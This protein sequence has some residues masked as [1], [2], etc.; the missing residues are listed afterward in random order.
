MQNS[1]NVL[2]R[3]HRKT[4]KMYIRGTAILMATGANLLDIRH[5]F[6]SIDDDL[7]VREL[8]N[9]T[10]IRLVYI[11]TNTGVIVMCKILSVVIEFFEC[12]S[13]ATTNYHSS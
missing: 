7:H 5:E 3:M 10:T 1:W 2:T 6:Y 12:L 8:M 11:R 4:K 13:L 9:I